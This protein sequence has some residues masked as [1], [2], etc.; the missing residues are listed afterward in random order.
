MFCTFF[1]DNF[2]RNLQ[3]I[4]QANIQTEVELTNAEWCDFI[5]LYGVRV[6]VLREDIR[7]NAVDY[8]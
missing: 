5:K 8:L 2:K 3:W 1:K 7:T 6:G 4:Y